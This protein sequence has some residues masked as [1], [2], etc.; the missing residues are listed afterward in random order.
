MVGVSGTDAVPAESGIT[1]RTGC[2]EGAGTGASQTL[3][4]QAAMVVALRRG[5]LAHASIAEA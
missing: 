1:V 3:T 5:W 2:E 4:L